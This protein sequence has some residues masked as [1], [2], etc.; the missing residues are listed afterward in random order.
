MKHS[1]EKGIVFFVMIIVTLTL[2]QIIWSDTIYLD[3]PY[4]FEMI[5]TSVTQNDESI[6]NGTQPW[7]ATFY[8]GGVEVGM[9]SYTTVTGTLVGNVVT[10]ATNYIP[11]STNMISIV[12]EEEDTA[13]AWYSSDY[14][15]HTVTNL[16]NYQTRMLSI[17][18]LG[19]W[20]ATSATGYIPDVPI[21]D[22]D[23]WVAGD[24]I[25][26]VSANSPELSH[27]IICNKKYITTSNASLPYTTVYQLHIFG[28]FPQ[29]DNTTGQSLFLDGFATEAACHAWVRANACPTGWTGNFLDPRGDNY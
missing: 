3:E 2:S 15:T 25:R 24:Y 26:E 21:D 12:V 8:A 27:K 18:N 1:L 14:I 28:R 22:S 11:S 17:A 7:R 13:G 20:G 29:V 6:T 10:A 9:A 16:N 19:V 5:W 23:T 4:R